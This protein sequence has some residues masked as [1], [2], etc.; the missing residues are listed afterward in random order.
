MKVAISVPSSPVTAT[1]G[2]AVAPNRVGPCGARRQGEQHGDPV[3]LVGQ[4]L[5]ID[6]EPVTGRGLA[7]DLQAG[8]PV[9][10]GVGDPLDAAHRAVLVA[11]GGP[12]HDG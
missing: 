3:D 9:G 6:G 5:Q 1:N 10:A 7:G 12:G 8:E 2:A 11:E 4:G